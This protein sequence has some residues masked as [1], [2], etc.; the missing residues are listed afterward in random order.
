[1][2]NFNI[3]MISPRRTGKSSMLASMI[4]NFDTVCSY[5]QIHLKADEST[6]DLLKNKTDSLEEKIK[7]HKVGESFPID[8]NRT[9]QPYDYTFTLTV[10]GSEKKHT[11]IFTDIN[12]GI[13]Y[14]DLELDNL[15]EKISKSQILIIAIDTPHLMEENGRFNKPFNNPHKMESLLHNFSEKEPVK[16]ILFIPLKCEKYYYEGRMDEVNSR[17]KMA[18]ADL[19]K[20]YGTNPKVKSQYTVAITPILTAGGIVFDD[21]GRDEFGEVDAIRESSNPELFYR[22]KKAFYKLYQNKPYFCPQFCE[23]PV[24]Y[25]LNFILKYDKIVVKK[26][27]KK[28]KQKGIM[29]AIEVVVKGIFGI[30]MSALALL[31]GDRD[32]LIELWRDLFSDRK[33]IEEA[34]KVKGNIKTSGDGYEIIQNPF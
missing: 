3:L 4:S 2:S 26:E 28:E 23:Q 30:L 13:I 25:L 1:M 6:K 21:F 27:V 31:L 16:L 14:N 5:S 7:K 34:V 22:P 10:N 24:L 18:Y 19:L 15:K 29:R 11:L 8:E 17:V 9:T 20:E 32:D 33:L 12:G